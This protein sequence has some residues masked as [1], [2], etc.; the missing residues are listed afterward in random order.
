M[1]SVKST[2]SWTLY[3]IKQLIEVRMERYTIIVSTLF[4]VNVPSRMSIF[5]EEILFETYVVHGNARFSNK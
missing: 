2:Y 1:S 5:L 3:F 4:D